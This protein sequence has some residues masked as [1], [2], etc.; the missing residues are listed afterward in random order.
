[1][2][3]ENV[4]LVTEGPSLAVTHRP[5]EEFSIDTERDDHSTLEAE[6][7]LRQP[8]L[9]SGRVLDCR[10]F[11]EHTFH[12]NVPQQSL[13]QRLLTQAPGVQRAQWAKHIRHFRMACSSRGRQTG[14]RENSMDVHDVEVSPVSSEPRRQWAR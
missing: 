8:L 10:S 1:A 2:E 9:R 13:A 12:A 7:L 14:V 11:V 3:N 6:R 4:R 5:A